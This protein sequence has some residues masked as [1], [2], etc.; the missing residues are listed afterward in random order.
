LD[1]KLAE[2]GIGP[3][4]REV[5]LDQPVNG[6][7]TNATYGNGVLV[8]SIPKAKS[9]TGSNTQFQLKAI[10]PTRGERIGY[11]GSEFVRR[12]M[13]KKN[14]LRSPQ[15]LPRTE[16]YRLGRDQTTVH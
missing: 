1:L 9:G 12:G 14:E 7:M 15:L 5:S 10:G 16:P 8:L 3:Y 11:T 2:W 13:T 4:F 6:A